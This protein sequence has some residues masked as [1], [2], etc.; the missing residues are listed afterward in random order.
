MAFTLVELLVVI[1]IIGILVALLLPAVQSAREAARRTQCSNNLKQLGLACLNFESAQRRLPPGY[2]A[3]GFFAGRETSQPGSSFPN[4][5]DVNH[6]YLG[7]ISYVLP[8][9]EQSAAYDKITQDMDTNVNK[10]DAPFFDTDKPNAFEIAQ[11]K[12][13]ALECPTNPPENPTYG[14]ISMYAVDYTGRFFRLR[15]GRL[16]ISSAPLGR[17]DY[18]GCTGLFG[19]TGVRDV[20][21]FVGA[22][23]VRS[24]TRLSQVT[25]GTSNSLL[26]GESP[27][28]IGEGITYGGTPYSGVVAQSAWIGGM[29]IPTAYGLDPTKFN[30]LPSRANPTGTTYQARNGIFSSLHT[31]GIVQ[32]CYVDGSVRQLSNSVDLDVLYAESGIMDGG[33]APPIYGDSPIVAQ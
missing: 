14:F 16:S 31:G 25:D 30:V 20:D 10:L 18:L 28:D 3:E 33:Q 5:M 23:S 19:E 1:A 17:T 22:F 24:R 11:W 9:F 12:F 15:S 8:Y 26:I 2:M 4:V 27:G 29:A 7:W 6:Q 32:F 13:A 21:A